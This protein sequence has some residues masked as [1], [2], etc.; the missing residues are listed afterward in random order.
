MSRTAPPPARG[1]VAD[2]FAIRRDEYS[3]Q[4]T[5]G[6]DR[7]GFIRID[8]D[9]PGLVITDLDP[10]SCVPVEAALA[11]ECAI[12]LAGRLA[13]SSLTVRDLAAGGDRQLQV[14]RL[15]AILAAYAARRRWAVARTELVER[16]HKTDL[17]VAFSASQAVSPAA[18]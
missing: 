7:R 9:A 8:T 1:P 12:G 16:G 2:R 13:C 3:L 5:S 6:Q 17:T 10:G 4:L 18:R 11:L 14:A 15:L